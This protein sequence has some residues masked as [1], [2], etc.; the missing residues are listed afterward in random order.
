MDFQTI[1]PFHHVAGNIVG[2]TTEKYI[3]VR[4]C[5]NR[6]EILMMGNEFEFF[7][8]QSKKYHFPPIFFR[9]E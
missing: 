7:L 9:Y 3:L 8:I 4:R 2:P 6:I 1:I 5:V